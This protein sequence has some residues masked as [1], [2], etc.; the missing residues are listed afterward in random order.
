MHIFLGFLFAVTQII[1]PQANR[2]QHGS[3]AGR[4]SV[5]NQIAHDISFSAQ[6]ATS[7]DVG[8]LTIHLSDNTYAYINITGGGTFTASLGA[9]AYECSIH[10]QSFVPNTPA[11]ILIDAHTSVR[12]TWTGNITTIDDVETS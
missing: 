9:E 12:V 5:A 1:A 10:G 6:N 7:V 4:I 11:R 2:F 3:E 8:W